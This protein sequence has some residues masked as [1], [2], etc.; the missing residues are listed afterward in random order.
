MLN[1]LHSTGLWSDLISLFIF[2]F[3]CRQCSRVRFYSLFIC[4]SVLNTQLFQNKS[5]LNFDS[6]L[7]LSPTF[8]AGLAVWLLIKK[9]YDLIIKTEKVKEMNHNQKISQT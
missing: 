5:L 1:P 4:L 2:V 8:S 6:A 7:H 3:S 9:I